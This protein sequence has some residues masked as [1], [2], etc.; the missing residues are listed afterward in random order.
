MMMI[1]T[2]AA[3]AA[4]SLAALPVA[5]DEDEAIDHYAAKDSETLAEAVENFVTYND[6]VQ[7][8]LARDELTPADMEEIHQYTY[9]IETAL[10]KINA[11]LG[12]LAVVLEEVHLAS[13]SDNP[14]RL[15]GAAEVYLEQAEALDR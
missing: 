3:A 10:A 13:E 14:A 8:V 2:L 1:R 11:E 9:T 5:A 7:E 15:R 12:A 6:K 4:L